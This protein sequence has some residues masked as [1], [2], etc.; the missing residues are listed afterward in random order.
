MY[1]AYYGAAG[2]GP[3]QPLEKHRWPCKEFV[4]LDDALLWAACVADRGTTVLA[5]DGDDGTQLNQ[6]D[7]AVGILLPQGCARSSNS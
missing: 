2:C 4:H 1:R 7:I 3:L 5:I 6:S